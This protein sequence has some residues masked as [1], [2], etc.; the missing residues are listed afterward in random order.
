MEILSFKDKEA[1][2]I[3]EEGKVLALPTET[4]Y[5]VGVRWDSPSAYSR[6]CDAKKRRPTK[7]I[8]VMTGTKFVLDDFFILNEGTKRVIQ[9]FLPG[10]LTVLVKA[11]EN[12]PE[13][14]HLG[15]FVAGIRI[16]GKPE[17]L[18]FLNSL[19]FPLQVTS[20]N[21]SGQP[22][23]GSFEEVKRIFQDNP[24]VEGIVRGTCISSIPTTVIDCTGETP[25]IIREG[26]IKL[27]DIIKTYKG[28]EK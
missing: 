2:E 15:T 26:E 27:V 13:Q 28:E 8:A 5:G 23:I 18:D 9:R 20:A 22:A 24:L 4:V 6:L 10:P 3:L 11:K 17:L 1:K 7:P 21:I 14:T 16:P 12:A 25:E 19:P